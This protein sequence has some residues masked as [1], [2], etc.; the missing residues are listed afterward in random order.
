MLGLG[1]DLSV[2]SVSSA[3]ASQMVLKFSQTK[4]TAPSFE[5]TYVRWDRSK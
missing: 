5:A 2:R 1:L 3:G 4:K